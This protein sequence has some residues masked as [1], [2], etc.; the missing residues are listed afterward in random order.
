M[1][2]RR[3]REHFTSGLSAFAH[4]AALPAPALP[5]PCSVPLILSFLTASQLGGA[6]FK[7]NPVSKNVSAVSRDFSKGFLFYCT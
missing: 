1:L 5:T 3:V 7:E 2:A 6:S 4:G